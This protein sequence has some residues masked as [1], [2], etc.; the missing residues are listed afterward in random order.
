MHVLTGE[1]DGQRPVLVEQPDELAL[2]LA[3]EDHPDDLHDLRGG[4]AQA[5]LELAGQP[6]P[7]EHRGDL[8]TA[9]VDDDRMQAGIPEEGD[10]LREGGLEGVVGHG[11]AAVLHDNERPTEALEP[12][13]CLDE[14]GRLAGGNAQS[15]GVDDTA[16]GAHH[17]WI[18]QAQVL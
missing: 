6:E 15:G 4:H 11:V 13:E 9:A 17:R 1:A 14:G 16:Q 8:R 10:V 7:G 3:G 5:A 18:L 12:R 2:H